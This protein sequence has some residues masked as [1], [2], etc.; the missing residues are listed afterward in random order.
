MN[1][2]IR[3][4]E[5]AGIFPGTP[6]AALIGLFCL[7]LLLC[8]LQVN[9][10]SA[11][12]AGGPLVPD[13]PQDARGSLTVT[14]CRQKDA[15]DDKRP[16]ELP[17]SGLKIKLY[18]AADLRVSGG[19]AQYLPAKGFADISPDYGKMTTAGSIAAAGKLAKRAGKLKA[20]AQGVTDADGRIIF[21]DL[22]PGMYLAVPQKGPVEM[23][24]C[25]WQIPMASEE[26]E[27]G[28]IS[29][30]YDVQVQ[31]KTQIRTPDDSHKDHGKKKHVRKSGRKTGQNTSV[32]HGPGVKTGDPTTFVPYIISAAAALAVIVLLAKRR[33]PEDQGE[34]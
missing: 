12:A 24:P 26:S 15:G 11:Y 8:F 5:N 14:V 2:R 32:I 27:N 6:A 16:E 23:A 28:R 10:I 18:L 21:H 13:I 1:D 31:P 3:K 33:D 4:R 30:Q 34:D 17:V 22:R 19:S 20:A 7:L 9:P 25:L 29:W